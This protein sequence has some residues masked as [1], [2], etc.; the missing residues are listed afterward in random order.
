[1]TFQV[2]KRNQ[3]TKKMMTGESISRLKSL[4]DL[5]DF[6]M[7]S[8]LVKQVLP[9]SRTITNLYRKMISFKR[10]VW[11]ESWKQLVTT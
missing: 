1:M 4:V 9:R 5:K 11:K 2:Q 10:L 8:I 6:K 3:K 7:P